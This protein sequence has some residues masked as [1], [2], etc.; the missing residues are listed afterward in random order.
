[1]DDSLPEGFFQRR[2][3]SGE[4]RGGWRSAIYLLTVHQLRDN[5]CRVVSHHATAM[6]R[7]CPLGQEA[8]LEVGIGKAFEH[9]LTH[10][11]IEQVDQRKQRAERIPE[12]RVGEHIA[13]QH[14]TIVR[15]VVDGVSFGIKLVEHTG[16][17]RGPVE[18]GIE[19]AQM[20]DILVLHLDASQHIVPALA[21]LLLDG[22]ERLV[23]HLLQVALGLFGGDER[24][25]HTDHHLLVLLR[26]EAG[27][28]QHM[29]AFSLVACKL[30]AIFLDSPEFKAFV[31]FHDEIV[32]EILWHTAAITSGVARDGA[33][34]YIILDSRALVEGIDYDAGDALF[35]HARL[36]E[37]KP[38]HG[39]TLRGSNF[40]P[41]VVLSQVHLIIIRARDLGVV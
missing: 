36:R 41:D 1:M 29:I 35:A 28:C 11:R 33:T 16:E 34:V 9:L 25:G 38:Q 8:T 18:A 4:R 31:D 20:V 26:Y 39:S 24:R 6:A 19:R 7:T 40:S 14:L 12:A 15:T 37:R 30:V 3:E 22:I 27:H 23:A 21:T 13:R 32:A 2:A 5:G 17:E 10:R